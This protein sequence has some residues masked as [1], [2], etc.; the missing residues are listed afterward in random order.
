MED[1]Q[2]STESKL[3]S[4]ADLEFPS[5]PEGT[6]PH[7]PKFIDPRIIAEHFAPLMKNPPSAEERWARKANAMP[8]LGV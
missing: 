4:L 6:Q 2:P 3:P 1:K 5:C 8:F 7:S